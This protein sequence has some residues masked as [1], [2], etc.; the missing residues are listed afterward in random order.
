M[1]KT[2]LIGLLTA[3]AL[4]G[5][6]HVTIYDKEV[7]GDLGEYGAHCAHTLVDKKR[8]ISKANWDQMRVGYLCMDSMAYNDTETSIDQFC[9]TSKLCDYKT[10]EQIAQVKARMRPVVKKALRARRSRSA[11]ADPDLSH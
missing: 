8:D 2:L 9:A 11:W 7:C 3:I 4:S 5:C 10:R 6:G 1:Q